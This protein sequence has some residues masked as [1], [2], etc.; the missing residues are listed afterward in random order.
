VKNKI[1]ACLVIA[2]CG[3]LAVLQSCKVDNQNPTIPAPVPTST[4]TSTPT[5]TPTP[6]E[7]PLTPC[8]THV[9]LSVAS[10]ASTALGADYT[11]IDQFTLA[12][13]SDTDSVTVAVSSASATGT[14]NNIDIALYTD[15]GSNYPGSVIFT[16]GVQHFSSTGPSTYVFSPSGFSL[17]GPGNYWLAVHSSIPYQPNQGG[18]FSPLD[19]VT[20]G[21][22][23]NPF[24]VGA[25][26][27]GYLWSYSMDTCHP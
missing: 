12:A 3:F 9:V 8:A 11:Y 27:P 17:M 20:A 6:T 5:Q 18:T 10:G 13:N 2:G 14:G 15:N 23:P 16:S 26:S 4:P 1:L 25:S 19:Y 24:P 22:F 7:T 21:K